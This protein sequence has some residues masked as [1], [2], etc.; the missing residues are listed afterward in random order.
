VQAALN[1]VYNQFWR[2]QLVYRHATM[3][4]TGISVDVLRA[5][6]WEVPARGP[7]SRLIAG[8]GFPFFALKERSIAKACIAFDYL[9]A[10]QTRLMPAAA[11]EEAGA[12]LLALAAGTPPTTAGTGALAR[13][14]A[15]DV[16][17]IVFV[18]FPQFPSSRVF[19]DA[20][21]V[22]V[23]EFHSR[24]PAEPG[25]LQIVPVPARPFPAALRDPDLLPAR[26]PASTYAAVIW[27]ILLLVGIPIF[28]YQRWR[29][30]GSRP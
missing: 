2:H 20:P 12:N 29:S 30:R 19:G 5:L 25:L 11:L 18:R 16:E 8:L 9:T 17:A 24:V 1:R 3:N 26:R 27:G 6:G 7:A 28:L 10:D 13:M 14:L 23:R 21:A 22:T 15:A 4:C